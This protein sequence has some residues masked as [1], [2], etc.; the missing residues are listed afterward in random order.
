MDEDAAKEKNS[1]LKFSQ[2]GGRTLLLKREEEKIKMERVE[3]KSPSSRCV[4]EFIS[5]VHG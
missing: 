2:S 5:F 1:A 3:I 4:C